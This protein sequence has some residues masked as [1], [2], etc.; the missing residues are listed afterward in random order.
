MSPE[1]PFRIAFW[2]LFGLVV[3]MRIYFMSRLRRSGG[4]IMPDRAAVR[5]EGNLVVA[6]RL[7]GFFVLIGLFGLYAIQPTVVETV[8]IPCPTWL[9]WVGLALGMVSVAFWTWVQAV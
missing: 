6:F 4:Q 1:S 2:V 9:R 8:S 5:R 7:L 3:V